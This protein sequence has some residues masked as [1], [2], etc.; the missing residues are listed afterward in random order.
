MPS[1]LPAGPV[2]TRPLTAKL[3][4]AAGSFLARTLLT[5]VL[6]TER[7]RYDQY[8]IV[9]G[10]YVVTDIENKVRW[11]GQASRKD[12]LPARLDSHHRQPERRAA[13]HHV[14]VVQLDDHTPVAA[15]NAI[16]GWCAD[17]LNLRHTMKP[18]RWPRSDNW[19]ALV[20]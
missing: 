20:A 7:W 8:A 13:F 17:Q 12:D 11:L 18:R 15:L 3:S 5:P 2:L 14:R 4:L 1:S 10:I 16:E 6:W 19:A 9:T